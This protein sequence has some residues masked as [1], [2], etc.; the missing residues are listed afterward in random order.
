MVEPQQ[1]TQEELMERVKNM[2]PEELQEFQKSRCIFCHIVAG[3]VPSKKV[4]DDSK[5]IAILD[6]NP[7]TEGH[8]LLMPK[9][10]YA[11]MPQVP[12]DEL[13]HLFVSTKKLSQ[14]ALK[15]IGAKGTNIV[16][17]NGVAAG[18]KAQHFMVH[19]IPRKEKDGLNLVLEKKSISDNDYNTVRE[20]LRKR[21]NELFGIKDEEV[22]EAE[23]VEEKEEAKEEP[24][25]K[26]KIKEEEVE[27]EEARGEETVEEADE[28]EEQGYEE[29]AP[30]VGEPVPEKFITSEKAKRYHTDKCAF[31]LN[32]PKDKKIILPEEEM[33]KM[34]KK[35][36]SCVTGRKIPLKK[37]VDETNA[38][39]D[40]LN[41][42]IE[43]LKKET[44][45][46]DIT[47]LFGGK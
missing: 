22:Q 42:D 5:I 13:D 46:D 15:A 10:H 36:C 38:E 26:E 21:I 1:E 43:D 34:G 2:S 19:L 14:I 37:E 8:V 12:E 47:K 39:V 29:E 32:I 18:Q 16:V 11:I 17:Q 24:F 28:K 30:D 9:E 3:K 33:E 40:E 20:R 44:D 4:Y 45:L 25:E 7:A 27:K 41:E 31:A 23:I 6:I 35:P